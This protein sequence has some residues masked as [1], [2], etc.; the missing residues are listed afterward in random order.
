MPQRAA[1]MPVKC[2][3]LMQCHWWIVWLHIIEKQGLCLPVYEYSVNF[4]LSHQS[5]CSSYSPGC[6]NIHKPAGWV[7]FPGAFPSLITLLI[8]CPWSIQTHLIKAQHQISPFSATEV[9]SS[10]FQL[11]SSSLALKFP[12]NFIPCQFKFVCTQ[13]TNRTW[14]NHLI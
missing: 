2:V 12:G 9:F 7:A 8:S 11:S 14:E 13:G 5:S 4:T 1:L 3:F 10:W 6:I